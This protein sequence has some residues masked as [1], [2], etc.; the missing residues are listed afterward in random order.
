MKRNILITALL[1]SLSTNSL[2]AM[3]K[4]LFAE[5]RLL[6]EAAKNN[7]VGQVEEAL[8]QEATAQARDEEGLTALHWAARNGNIAIIKMLIAHGAMAED[9]QNREHITPAQ[10]A[11]QK[12]HTYTAQYLTD[13]ANEQAVARQKIMTDDKIRPSQEHAN[14]K[15]YNKAR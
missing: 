14:R 6:L 11:L 5:D 12:R 10:A 8:Y 2:I 4:E 7:N 1:L 15:E 9:S 13:I 3:R